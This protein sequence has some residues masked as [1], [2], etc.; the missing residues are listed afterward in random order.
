MHLLRRNDAE[1][2]HRSRRGARIV[3][4]TE[5]KSEEKARRRGA[6]LNSCP[7]FME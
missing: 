7:E 1:K 3:I 4:F 2:M 5:E 6:G